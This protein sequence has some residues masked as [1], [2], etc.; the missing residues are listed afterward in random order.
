MAIKGDIEGAYKNMN[1]K[2][3]IE[4]LKIQISD[5]KFLKILIQGFKCGILEMFLLLKVSKIFSF[6]IK[7]L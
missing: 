2:I 6:H 1:H 3:L 4:I 7:K 5:E